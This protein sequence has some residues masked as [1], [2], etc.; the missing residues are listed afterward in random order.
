VAPADAVAPPADASGATARR[1]PAPASSAAPDRKIAV[2]VSEIV[3]RD[4]RL[5]WRDQAVTPA[6]RLDVSDIQATTRSIGWPLRGTVPVTLRA[7]APG[8]GTVDISGRVGLEPLAA[9]ARVRARGAELSPYQPYASTPARLGGRADLDVEV[10]VPPGPDH[11]ATVRGRAALSDVDI[12]DGE[13]TVIRVGRAAA[14][15]ID[16]DWPVRLDVRS[17]ALERPWIL[18]ER[19][20]S[21]GLAIRRLLPNAAP[22]PARPDSDERARHADSAEA[23]APSDGRTPSDRGAPPLGVSVAR[24]RVDDGGAR[25]VDRS[26]SPPFAVDMDRLAASVQGASTAD[27]T[28]PARVQLDGRIARDAHLALR[29]TVALGSPL[30]VDVDGELRQFAVPRANPYL[31]R[32]VAWEA[33][34]GWITT[35]LHCRIDGDALHARSDIRIGQLELARAARGDQVQARIGLPLGFLVSL[36]KDAHGEIHVALPIGG[37]LGDPRFDFSEAIWSAIKTVAIKAVTL[38][39]S[40]IGRVRFGRDEKIERIDVDPIRFEPGTATLTADGQEQVSR[41]SRFLRQTSE[42]RIALTPVLSAEDATALRRGAVEKRLAALTRDRRISLADAA[43]RL[44]RER[45]P[46]R[47]PPAAPDAVLASLVETAPVPASELRELG[48]RRAAAVRE[49]L[50][51]TGVDDSRLVASKP[52]EALEPGDAR[53]ALDLVEPDRSAKPS[54]PLRRLLDRLGAARADRR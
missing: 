23:S 18:V 4:G 44:Y 40:W 13:R 47:I 31:L 25:I 36:M 8:G 53:V 12:R 52:D 10:A 16:L 21:G 24:L 5:A 17:L 45:F 27:G 22:R 35:K 51:G 2:Q 29:G 28:P 15:G 30:R 26:I 7:T 48:E 3:L 19:D 33:R 46:D 34:D 50:S 32:G 11:R 1:T 37:R 38:P 39:V 43:A 9:E 20:D 54:S 49:M 14:D 42:I 6:A 41:V